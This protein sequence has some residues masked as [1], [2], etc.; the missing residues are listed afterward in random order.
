MEGKSLT[1]EEMEAKFNALKEEFFQ[2]MEI[3]LGK[4]PKI[5]SIE[6]QLS[7]FRVKV[8][9]ITPA[10]QVLIFY[11]WTDVFH[12]CMGKIQRVFLILT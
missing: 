5:K 6:N 2:D 9:E 8:E 7:N 1:E 12:V 3:K 10:I 11:N 4:S